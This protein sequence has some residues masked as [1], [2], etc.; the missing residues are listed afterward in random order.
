MYQLYSEFLVFVF[1][2]LFSF[3]VP[4]ELRKMVEI[5]NGFITFVVQPLLYLHGDPR[6][7]IRIMNQG[8]WQALKKELF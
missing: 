6:F 3:L 2:F 1:A 4:N 8:M 7:R 5:V